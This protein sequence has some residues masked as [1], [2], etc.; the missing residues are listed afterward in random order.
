M[1]YL[2]SFIQSQPRSPSGLKKELQVKDKNKHH[3]KIN[4]MAMMNFLD[5]N[6][7]YLDFTQTVIN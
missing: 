4:T 1:S 5:F 3:M 7:L 6:H 2:V